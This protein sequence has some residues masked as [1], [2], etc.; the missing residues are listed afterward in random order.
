MSAT[1]AVASVTDAQVID[2]MMERGGSF[3]SALG[4]AARRADSENLQRIKV[5]WPE[6]WEA[7][8]LVAA[9]FATFES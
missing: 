9:H 2:A 1:E 6:Y 8:T 5:T 4:Q 3:V 7:Y